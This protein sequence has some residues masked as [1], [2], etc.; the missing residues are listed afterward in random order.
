MIKPD[1]RHTRLANYRE[2]NHHCHKFLSS[3][4]RLVMHKFDLLKEKKGLLGSLCYERVFLRVLPGFPLNNYTAFPDWLKFITKKTKKN[5]VRVSEPR[6]VAGLNP[7]CTVLHTGSIT[8]DNFS[9]VIFEWLT[10]SSHKPQEIY[11]SLY[12]SLFQ[13]IYKYLLIRWSGVV[14][15]TICYLCADILSFLKV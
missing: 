7:L 6:L 14:R 11:L 13:L 10:T 3:V 9:A 8:L 12:S 2:T 15:T 5:S 4:K 1:K